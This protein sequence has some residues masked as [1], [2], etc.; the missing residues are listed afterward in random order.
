VIR[1]FAARI[2]LLKKWAAVRIVRPHMA[3]PGDTF[4]VY[5]IY[6]R[7]RGAGLRPGATLCV[8]CPTGVGPCP[9]LGVI[10]PA[11]GIAY[12]L[13]PPSAGC[14]ACPNRNTYELVP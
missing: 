12:I 10:S 1:T 9:R 4:C 7:S 5:E 14:R 13:S 6:W 2:P 8:H 3:L 11:P